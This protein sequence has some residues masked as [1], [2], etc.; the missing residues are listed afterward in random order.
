MSGIAHVNV[1]DVV[2]Q[3]ASGRYLLIMVESRPWGATAGQ[4]AEL[5]KKIDAYERFIMDGGLARRYPET[6][7]QPVDIQLNCCET[8]TGQFA[9]II[10]RATTQLQRSGSFARERLDA[11]SG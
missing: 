8:P 5:R 7:G 3:D 2:G 4:A 10:A 11:L 6:T 9:T 1:V